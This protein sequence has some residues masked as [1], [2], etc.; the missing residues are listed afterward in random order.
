VALLLRIREIPDSNLGEE[1]DYPEG[2]FNGF[3]LSLQKNA[4]II[5]IIPN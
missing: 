2:S 5:F 1:I 3:P 4:G